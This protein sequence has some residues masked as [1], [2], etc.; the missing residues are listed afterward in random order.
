MN[1]NDFNTNGYVYVPNA[2]DIQLVDFITQ[3]A[4]FDEMQQFQP[5]KSQVIGAHSKYADPAMESLLLTLLPKM[6]ENTNLQLFPTYSY[7]RVYRPGDELKPHKDRP[8]CEV[9]CTVCFNFSYDSQVYQWPIYMENSEVNMNPGDMVIY[10]GCELTHYR[11]PLIGNEDDWHVQ[12]FF[13]YVNQHGP[14]KDFKYDKRE[15]V[16]TLNKKSESNYPNYITH[17]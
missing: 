8:S 16:G 10:K 17:V 11:H 4:L 2:V 14:Y 12:G 1:N 5:D 3:Y 13:H 15:S 9:S 7:F 6:E